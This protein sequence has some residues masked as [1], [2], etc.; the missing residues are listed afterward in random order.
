MRINCKL[1][2]QSRTFNGQF[3]IDPL[4]KAPVITSRGTAAGT[5]VAG[6]G[7]LV[8]PTGAL[9]TLVLAIITLGAL[10]QVA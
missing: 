9:A 6:G 7:P 3:I 5:E 8:A 4:K 10:C 2:D 1:D